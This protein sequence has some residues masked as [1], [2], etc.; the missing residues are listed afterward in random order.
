MTELNKFQKVNHIITAFSNY[1]ETDDKSLI[2]GFSQEQLLKTKNLHASSSG[3][4]NSG[5][6]LAI[7]ERLEEM[8]NEEKY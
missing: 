1:L 2:I 7:V 5:W 6:Y 4:R 3:D 8:K